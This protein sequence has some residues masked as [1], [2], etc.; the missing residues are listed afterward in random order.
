M[1][2]GAPISHS[3]L[4]AVLQSGI[5]VGLPIGQQLAP[6]RPDAESDWVGRIVE[7]GCMTGRFDRVEIVIVIGDGRMLS[8]DRKTQL[9]PKIAS[10]PKCRL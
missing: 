1:V 9:R 5:P 8:N 3:A 6:V 4:L 2:H 7:P 10:A